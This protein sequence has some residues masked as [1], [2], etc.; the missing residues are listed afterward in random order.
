MMDVTPT[1]EHRWLQRLAGV[2]TSEANCVMGPD[3][4]AVTMRGRETVRMLGDVWMIG[5]GTGEMPDGDT[6]RTV[7]TLGFDPAKGRFVGSFIGSMMTMMWLYDGALDAAGRVLTLQAE[8]PDMG[9]PGRIALYH[10]IIEM[11][12]DGTRSLTSRMQDADG[13]WQP[14]MSAHYRR[15]G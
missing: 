4:P 2:W 5:E 7:M 3:Q 10:D 9:T 13:Q 8:G 14:V 11:L 15:V 12:D 1:A 6:G